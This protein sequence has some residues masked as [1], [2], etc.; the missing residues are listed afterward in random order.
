MNSKKITDKL[1]K[2]IEE[3]TELIN[4]ISLT[5]YI[6]IYVPLLFLMFAAANY[7]GS[8]FFEA[9]AFDWRRIVIQAVLFGIFFR[10][11]HKGRKMWNDA[12]KN[13]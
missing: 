12:W 13:K 10:V 1:N 6:L 2:N 11:F 9:V 8:L 4:K 7:L 5:K 3:E